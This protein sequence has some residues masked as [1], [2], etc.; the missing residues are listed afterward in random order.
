MR[1]MNQ[2]TCGVKHNTVL[3]GV[4]HAGPENKGK[5]IVAIIPSCAE[6]YLSSWLFADVNVESDLLEDILPSAVAPVA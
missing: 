5:Q 1:V 3:G 6:R 2:L 4:P